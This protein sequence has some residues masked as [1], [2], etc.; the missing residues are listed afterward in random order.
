MK[1][2]RLL[3][4]ALAGGGLFAHAA[5]SV[6]PAVMPPTAKAAVVETFRAPGAP[7][8]DVSLPPPEPGALE[9]LRS[10]NAH[11]KRLE[12]GIGRDL[13]A[14]ERDAAAPRWI[15]TEGGRVA[16]WRVR[17]ESAQ[18]L[19]VALRSPDWPADAQLRFA[20]NAESIVYGPVSGAQAG[21]QGA[22]YWSPVLEGDTA[23]VEIFVPRGSALPQVDL[24]RVSH[25][26][27]SFAHPKAE[28]A[29]KASQPCQVNFICRSATE[30]ALAE[31]GRSVAR[32][33]FTTTEGRSVLCSGTLLNTTTGGL[34][35][36]FAT[37]GHCIG[38]PSEAASIA[39]RWFYETTT[40]TGTTINPASSQLDGGATL[41]YTNLSEDFALVRLNSTP[42]ANAVF[43]GWDAAR[44]N[45]GQP[46]TGIHH[47]DGD[48]KKVSLGTAAGVGQSSVADGNGFRIQW[49]GALT[50]FTE[51]GSS[52]SGIFTG[53]PSAGYRFRGTLQGGPIGACTDPPADLYD[54]YSRFDLAFPFIAQY[55]SPST[56]PALGPNGLAN[57]GFEAG[58]GSWTQTVSA[59]N[60]VIITNDPSAA[61]SGG[62]YAWL[63]GVNGL[64]DSVH[65]NLTIPAGAARL[66][67]WYRVDTQETSLTTAFDILTISLADPSSGATLMELGTLS[68][69]DRTSTWVQ[70]PVYDVSAFAN[71][72]VRLVLR[73]VTDGS[74]VTSFRVD[75]IAVQGTPSALPTG[76]HTALWLKG[77]EAGWGLNVTHQ[78]DIVF[79][80]LFTYAAN[81]TPLWLVTSSGLRQEGAATFRGE[82]YRTTGP[83]FNAQ[84]FPPIGPSNYTRVGSLT[85]DYNGST[86]L[87]GYD[88]DGAYVSK[89][90]QK[91]VF[92]PNPNCV[93]TT[94][95]R[96]NATNYQDLWLKADEAGWGL[97]IT[98]QGD[99]LFATLFTYGSNGQGLWLV[100]SNGSRQ[101]DGSYL[102]DLYRTS[103]PAFNAVPFTPITFPQNYTL[104]GT[105]R[106]RFQDGERGTL[107][108][109]VNGTQVVKQV[110]RFVF[111]SPVPLC[112]S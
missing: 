94:Q 104:V 31:A 70:G 88:V 26:F 1:L 9:A 98:H 110:T 82:L 103:G 59:G 49:T 11:S 44:L 37:A 108:Y 25:L 100:M 60:S 18:S 50:G 28:L 75:D 12:V 2:L 76:N 111:A 13:P 83:P 93:G 22:A 95:S 99:I 96:A 79:A 8:T 106:L 52:G 14:T 43:S 35:P 92:G 33:T 105:M 42:P 56:S 77:D 62:W 71:R 46:V 17:S 81:G 41:L 72:A 66:Q 87:L 53:N 84:P 7:T 30:S 15:A 64:T 45:P 57:P 107:D 34:T 67:F 23:T 38:A 85:V 58:F 29:A 51:P 90:I 102:G 89:V 21:A 6:G 47:P 54:Y 55:L 40:C 32:I 73:S 69:R 65:Q 86:A 16:R 74:L 78:G 80:T 20:G 68:N 39:T 48:P 27:V 24:A 91:H 19:R 112:G 97:N 5:P 61:H 63:G 109:T 3:A 4:L 101:A 10:A 36:Y